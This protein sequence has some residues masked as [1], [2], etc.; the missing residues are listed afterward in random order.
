MA[1]RLK[2]AMVPSIVIQG[3]YLVRTSGS[4]GPKRMLDVMDY[5]LAKELAERSNN[6]PQKQAQKN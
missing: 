6:E 1:R 4:V 3:K 5:L 2:V